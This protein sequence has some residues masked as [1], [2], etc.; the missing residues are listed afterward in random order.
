MNNSKPSVRLAVWII[1]LFVT[2]AQ[3]VTTPL[4]EWTAWTFLSLLGALGCIVMVII[5][6]TSWKRSKDN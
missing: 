5:D 6:F 2:A 3:V 1:L 4:G